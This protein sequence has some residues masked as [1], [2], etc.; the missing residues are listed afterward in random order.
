MKSR[1]LFLR[2]AAVAL[3][4]AF[5]AMDGWCGI[6]AFSANSSAATLSPNI[7]IGSNFFQKSFLPEKHVFKSR[8]IW[9][10]QER[11]RQVIR[12]LP[13]IGIHGLSQE[14]YRTVMQNKEFNGNISVVVTETKELSPDQFKVIIRNEIKDRMLDGLRNMNNLL[15]ATA[16]DWDK[17]PAILFIRLLWGTDR[18][19]VYP[20]LPMQDT[21]FSPDTIDMK[22]LGAVEFSKTDYEGLIRDLKSSMR[23]KKIYGYGVEMYMT[24]QLFKNM[25]KILYERTLDLFV[26]IAEKEEQ[27]AASSKVRKKKEPLRIARPR[28]VKKSAFKDNSLLI[29][30]AI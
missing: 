14:I 25:S 19:W 15:A 9:N 10:N 2:F 5:L 6:N 18:K 3:I 27:A 4:Q 11:A 8:R 29:E 28:A 13:I 1:I 21:T 20:S 26:T 30:H 24:E 17:L 16:E 23:L 12:K 22:L 7:T